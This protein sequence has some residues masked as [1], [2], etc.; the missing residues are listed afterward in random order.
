[1][2]RLSITESACFVSL[3]VALI[4]VLHPEDFPPEFILMLFLCLVGK[5]CTCAQTGD[6][7]TTKFDGKR[8]HFQGICKYNLATS[9]DQRCEAR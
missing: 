1:M 8:F 6:P 3:F 7:H 4:Y 9:N 5:T 2:N